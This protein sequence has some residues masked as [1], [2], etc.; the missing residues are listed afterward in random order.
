MGVSIPQ[1]GN[2]EGT[3]GL[4]DPYPRST[5]PPPHLDDPAGLDTHINGLRRG[6]RRG[7]GAGGRATPAQRPQLGAEPEGDDADVPDEQVCGGVIGHG[8][9]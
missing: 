2:E 7:Q 1:T 8:P 9:L 3:I 6:W 4:K 5:Q